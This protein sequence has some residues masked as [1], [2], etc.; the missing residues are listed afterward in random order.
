MTEQF[1]IEMKKKIE[2]TEKLTKELWQIKQVKTWQIKNK[3][4]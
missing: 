3:K 1:I 2:E 4:L